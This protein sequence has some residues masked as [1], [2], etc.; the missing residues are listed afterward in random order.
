MSIVA[1]Q[2][3]FVN[4]ILEFVDTARLNGWFFLSPGFWL[5]VYRGVLAING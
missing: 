5:Y 2:Q 3:P 1:V 4:H